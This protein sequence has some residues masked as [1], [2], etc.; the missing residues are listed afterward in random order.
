MDRVTVKIEPHI[1]ARLRL[2][3][4]SISATVGQQ[5]TTSQ[6]IDYLLSHWAMTRDQHHLLTAGPDGQIV[7]PSS[8][9]P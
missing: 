5:L 1:A 4:V 9:T 2:A 8:A 6:A 7:S 3:K